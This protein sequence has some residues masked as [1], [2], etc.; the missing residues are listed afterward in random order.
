MNL[1]LRWL[2]TTVA[3]LLAAYLLPG[4]TIAGVLTAI[5][6]ALVLGIINVFLKP[7]LIILTLPITLLTFGLFVFVINALLVMLTANLVP[8]F[9]VA[10][11][12][13]ALL[14]SLIVSLV[15]SFFHAAA[16]SNEP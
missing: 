16:D 1:L 9:A 3:V 7:L 15:T 4:V 11:F 6:V 5:I 14:F 2:I 13:W 10:N 12:W 8:G